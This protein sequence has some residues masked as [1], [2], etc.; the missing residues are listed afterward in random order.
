MEAGWYRENGRESPLIANRLY[1]TILTTK[2]YFRPL[3]HLHWARSAI[4][5]ESAS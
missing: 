2:R 4:N 1:C 5:R 3:I